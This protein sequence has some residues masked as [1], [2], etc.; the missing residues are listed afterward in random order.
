MSSK[1]TTGLEQYQIQENM[2]VE[3]LRQILGIVIN[4]R[5]R[6][7]SLLS[8]LL[9]PRNCHKIVLLLQ[10]ETQVNVKVAEAVRKLQIYAGR[11][12]RVITSKK[13]IRE[14]KIYPAAL[15]K[16]RGLV[17]ELLM[18]A[19]LT[20]EQNLLKSFVARLESAINRDNKVKAES[21][22]YL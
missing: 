16:Y 3:H 15:D 19:G 4:T 11:Y 8:D 2:A 7:E 21:K 17:M 22:E 14:G 20:N 5:D 18:R 6:L 1:Y 9:D 13:A 12:L 10:P